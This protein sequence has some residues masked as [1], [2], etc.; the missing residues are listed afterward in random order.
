MASQVV[1]L[2]VV[3]NSGIASRSSQAISTS[4]QWRHWARKA[5]SSLVRPTTSSPAKTMNSGAG[6]KRWRTA[7]VAAKLASCGAPGTPEQA[8]P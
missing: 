1:W 8:S 2:E 5:A 3:W 4:S 6:D 7:L